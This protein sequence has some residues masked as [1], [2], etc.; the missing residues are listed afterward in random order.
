MALWPWKKSAE[1]PRPTAPPT[2]RAPELVVLLPKPR[3]ISRRY[4]TEATNFTFG[5]AIPADGGQ[6]PDSVT[7][8]APVFHAQVG[9]QLFMVHYGKHPWFDPICAPFMTGDPQTI[10]RR[11]AE[12]GIRDAVRSA[13]GWIAVT[14]LGAKR[15]GSDPY[16]PVARLLGALA[17]VED[18]IAI[19]WPAQNEVQAWDPEMSEPL[20]DGKYAEVFARRPGS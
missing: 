9:G 6:G 16:V 8:D 18:V 19:V 2:A 5:T 1:P 7:G 14:L 13:G 11:A 12:L 17:D 3:E 10:L 20:F 15:D 4:L